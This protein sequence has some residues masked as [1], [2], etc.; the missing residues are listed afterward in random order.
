M[1][2]KPPHQQRV[3]EEKEALDIKIEALSKFILESPIFNNLPEDERKRLVRQSTC[4]KEYSGI[5]NERIE[6][7]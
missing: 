3:F 5:L 7:F 1:P 4:M 6:A 2:P